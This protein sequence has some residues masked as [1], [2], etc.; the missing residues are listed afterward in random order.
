MSNVELLERLFAR[1]AI[2]L[3][4]GEPLDRRPS[5]LPTTFDWDRIDGMMLGLAIGDALGNTTESMP[6]ARRREVGGEIRDYG[7][8][9]GVGPIASPSDAE[10]LQTAV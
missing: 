3:R 10:G 1:G 8:R 2:D 5:P 9:L 7:A 4:R 6:P